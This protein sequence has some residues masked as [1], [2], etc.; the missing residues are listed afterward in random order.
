MGSINLLPS[1]NAELKMNETERMKNRK[2]EDA[3]EQYLRS[4]KILSLFENITARLVFERPG[5]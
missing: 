1:N 2:M 4:H 5:W 3:A